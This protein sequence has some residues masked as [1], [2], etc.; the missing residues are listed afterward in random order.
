MKLF[1][2]NESD[3]TTL[4][5]VIGQ[6]AGAVSMCWSGVSDAGIFQSEL[7]A[8]FVT[9]MVE[10]VEAHYI[11]I[12]LCGPTEDEAVCAC[13]CSGYDER[14]ALYLH[15]YH[16]TTQVPAAHS[17]CIIPERILDAD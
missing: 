16:G 7:A 12:T 8:G 2:G 3:P 14:C 1:R 4:S 11:P 17:C 9:E 5:E 6:G 15:H 13:G 10:W